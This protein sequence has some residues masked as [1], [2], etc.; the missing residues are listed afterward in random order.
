MIFHLYLFTISVHVR[1][2]LWSV[3]P[4]GPVSCM[5][6]MIFDLYLFVVQCHVRTNMIFDLYLLMVHCH[7]RTTWSSVSTHGSV[8]CKN[9]ISLI[10]ISTWLDSFKNV[11][12]LY[13]LNV[14]CHVRT[15]WLWSVS[16]HGSVSCKNYMIFDLYLL[17]V[18]CHVRTTWSLISISSW[19]SV[20]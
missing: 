8:P 16:P 10:C 12:D 3:S 2:D 9:Y 7:V 6:E 4:H 17:M 19:F 1:S 11:S 13:L 20:M 14:E 5:I 15:T 18:Q